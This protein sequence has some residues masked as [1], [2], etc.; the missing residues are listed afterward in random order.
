VPERAI[1]ACLALPHEADVEIERSLDELSRLVETAGGIVVARCVQKRESPDPATYFGRGKAEEIRNLAAEIRADLLVVEKEI[2]PTQQR[3]L[4]DITGIRVVDR[5]ALILDIFARHAT[6]NEGKIQVELAQLTYLRP[7]LTGRGRELSRLGGGIGT[8]GPG[9]TKL[10]VDRRRI[11]DRIAS[12]KRKLREVEK[13]R[14]LVRRRRLAHSFVVSFV[15]YTNAG[16]SSL[17]RALTGADV[18]VDDRLFATLDP[19]ARRLYL[20]DT[21]ENAGMPVVLIDTVGFI[22]NLPHQLVA[23]FHSTLEEV[24]LADLLLHVVDASDPRWEKHMRVVERTLEEIGAAQVPRLVVFNKIDRLDEAS[25]AWFRSHFPQAV[26][27]SATSGAGLDA[28][29]EQIRLRARTAQPA[30]GARTQ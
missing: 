17:E 13:H 7:R 5:T 22:E 21:P 14:H 23:A 8:R 30:R 27:V 11:N 6:S 2:S 16:K 28:L 3:H 12:L 19:T 4:E 20:G 9:E 25:E 1:V 15:G 10:E 26:F 29:Q 18:I 24:R